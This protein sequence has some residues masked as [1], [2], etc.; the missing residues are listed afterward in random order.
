MT[1]TTTNTP[2]LDRIIRLTKSP[3]Q[4]Q[5]SMGMAILN[6]LNN[7]F[8]NRTDAVRVLNEINRQVRIQISDTESGWE[9]PNSEDAIASEADELRILKTVYGNLRNRIATLLQLLCVDEDDFLS[10]NALIREYTQ[11]LQALDA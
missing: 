11:T 6:D 8:Y 10:S 9:A 3:N 7:I 4:Q 5:W 2:N 1:N